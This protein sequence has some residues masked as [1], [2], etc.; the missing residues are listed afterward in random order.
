MMLVKTVLAAIAN[1]RPIT[2][3]D[4]ISTEILPRTNRI[5]WV[6]GAPR[7]MREPT[8][9]AALASLGSRFLLCYQR[10]CAVGRLASSRRSYFISASKHNGKQAK[11]AEGDGSRTHRKEGKAQHLPQASSS[12]DRQMGVDSRHGPPHLFHHL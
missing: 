7:A 6:R 9:S 10:G 4:A 8:A 1:I 5:T 12:I 3:P 11:T 2:A